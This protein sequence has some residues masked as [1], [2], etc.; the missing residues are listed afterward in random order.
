MVMAGKCFSRLQ[1]TVP[2]QNT[3]SY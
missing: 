1:N 3:R 2:F